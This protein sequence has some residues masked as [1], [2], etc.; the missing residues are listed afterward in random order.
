MLLRFGQDF[1]G[2][3]GAVKY[4]STKAL[5]VAE[6]KVL[7]EEVTLR[8]IAE[9]GVVTA[10]DGYQTRVTDR[11][12][13]AGVIRGFQ[14]NGIGPREAGD[15]LGGNMF[16]SLRFEAEFPLGIPEEY[17]ISGG[18]F[19]DMGSVWGLNNVG[20]AQ[21]VDSALR[22]AGGL[23]ILWATPIGPLRMN[24]SRPIKMESYDI[25]QNFELTLS[26]KF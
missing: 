3:G 15:A 14:R 1:A 10:L 11:F 23:S 21:G 20:T 12:F 26:T 18:A 7:N 2:L 13:G 16:A 24:F 22:S 19:L 25:S 8:A 9:G 5:A 4:I 17:G 6:A